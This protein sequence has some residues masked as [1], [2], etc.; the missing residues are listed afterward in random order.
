MKKMTKVNDL[1]KKFTVPLIKMA[2]N[3][4]V[5]V[6]AVRE[7]CC[8]LKID[9]ETV[10]IV[11]E[12]GKGLKLYCSCAACGKS[13]VARDTLCRRRIRAIQFLCRNSGCISEIEIKPKYNL[14]KGDE[15][16]EQ[17]ND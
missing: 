9:D 11:K 2:I 13:A 15:S 10:R 4:E 5:K 8:Y 17:V 7:D 16:N 3:S 12:P 1:F 6:E 14:K